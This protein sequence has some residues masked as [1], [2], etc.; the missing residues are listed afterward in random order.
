[1]NTHMSE[2][3][4]IRH[5]SVMLTTDAFP[6]PIGIAQCSAILRNNELYFNRL[7]VHPKFRR[8]GYGTMLLKRLLELI[9]QDERQL[10]LDINP[11]GEMD[12][13]QLEAFYLKHGFVK[14]Q[15]HEEGAF[16]DYY[17]YYFNK[18]E[19]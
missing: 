19:I 8:Q 14:Y 2:Q 3:I 18:K 12:Y 15:M 5:I 9:V 13:L 1:M 10:Q 7:Y 6:V 11:Y 17:T 16:G 4:G